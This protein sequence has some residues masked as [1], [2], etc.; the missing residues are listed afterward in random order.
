MNNNNKCNFIII[1]NNDEPGSQPRYH[2]D[3]FLASNVGSPQE[4]RLGAGADR[5]RL[6]GQDNGLDVG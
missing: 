2:F 4:S 6:F 1:N 5:A 3:V